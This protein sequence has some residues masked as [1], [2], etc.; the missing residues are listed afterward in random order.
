MFLQE[1]VVFLV[2]N[3]KIVFIIELKIYMEDVAIFIK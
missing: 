2:I 3:A 1:D